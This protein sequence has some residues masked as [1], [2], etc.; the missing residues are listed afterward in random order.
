MLESK[1]EIRTSVFLQRINLLRYQHGSQFDAHEC[2]L[3]LLNEIYP[4]IDDSWIFNIRLKTT[5]TC[6]KSTCNHNTERNSY[7]SAMT[8]YITD[9][10][11]NWTVTELLKNYLAP[12]YF[13]G[14]KCDCCSDIN[15]CYELNSVTDFKHISVFQLSSFEFLNGVMTK[16]GYNINTEGSLVMN[17]SSLKIHGVI[18]HYGLNAQNGYYT[19]SVKR[20]NEWYSIS[21]NIDELGVNL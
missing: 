7:N 4:D 2:I 8:L 10:S 16:A 19:C 9:R 6:N 21:D 12:G 3:V 11:K 1:S 13:T 20:V 14:Y 17:G 18:F 5:V 15:T